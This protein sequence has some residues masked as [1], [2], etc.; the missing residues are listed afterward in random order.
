MLLRQ[1][2]SNHDTHQYGIHT[3]PF[4][5]IIPSD[6]S[7]STPLTTSRKC[8][9]RIGTT[10]CKSWW[11]IRC[12]TPT[13]WLQGVHD[14]LVLWNPKS[15]QTTRVKTL[16]SSQSLVRE[17]STTVMNRMCFFSPWHMLRITTARIREMRDGMLFGKTWAK[18]Q[19]SSH[20][21]VQR[22]RRCVRLVVGT[23]P[24]RMVNQNYSWEPRL[25]AFESDKS[26]AKEL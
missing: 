10:W 14:A 26:A 3:N 22:Y 17:W 11:T 25:Y 20:T 1:R 8:P 5:L 12:F 23:P 2:Q 18:H 15:C 6:S 4:R 16:P 21:R 13:R 9:S 24:Q 7:G 19:V